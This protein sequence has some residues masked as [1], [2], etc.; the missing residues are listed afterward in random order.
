MA[1]VGSTGKHILSAGEIA[2]YVV[3][4]ESWR[5]AHLEGE[6]PSRDA[7]SEKGIKLHSDW[8]RSYSE[9]TKLIQGIRFSLLLLALGIALYALVN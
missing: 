6:R 7:H 9:S 1:K 4:P 5:L 3:C 2:A 8:A